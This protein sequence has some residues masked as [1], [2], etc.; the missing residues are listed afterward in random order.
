MEIA[1]ILLRQIDLF[2]QFVLQTIPEFLMLDFQVLI[3]NKTKTNVNQNSFLI[4]CIL[5]IKK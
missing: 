1:E 3:R 2:V 5:L 4:S